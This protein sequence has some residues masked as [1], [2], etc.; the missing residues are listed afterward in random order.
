[1]LGAVILH[2]VYPPSFWFRLPTAV[3]ELRDQIRITSRAIVI[4][5]LSQLSCARICME[6]KVLQSSSNFLNFSAP[7]Y[8][9]SD[10]QISDSMSGAARAQ[11][12]DLRVAPELP[13][14]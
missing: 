10:V 4:P 13:G 11:M 7:A 1:M 6:P 9:A 3:P 5:D 12:E 14:N 2:C 8:L